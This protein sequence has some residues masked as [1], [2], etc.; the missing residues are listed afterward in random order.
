MDTR[1]SVR[2]VAAIL[3]ACLAW[4]LA[5]ADEPGVAA[6]VNGVAIS[7]FRLER[8]FEDFL[9]DRGRQ[10]QKITHPSAYKR[11]KREALDELIDRELLWQAAQQ[12]GVKIGEEE[13]DQAM[14][15]LRARFP[16]AAAYRRRLEEAGFS[17]KSYREYVARDL[18]GARFLTARVPPPGVVDGEVEAAYHRYAREASAPPPLDAV[19]EKIR[20]HLAAEQ[21][22]NGMAQAVEALR[23]AAKIERILPL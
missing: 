20:A 15:S 12:A 17:E 22:R 10:L 5:W 21:R 23:A 3:L 9:K 16:D 2:S 13:L 1:R 7:V 6:R 18:A 11:L 8:H 4:S 19:R 14:A